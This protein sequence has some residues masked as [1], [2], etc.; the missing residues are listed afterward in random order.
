LVR[1]LSYLIFNVASVTAVMTDLSQFLVVAWV[2]YPDLIP[3][4]G[5]CIVPEPEQPFIERAPHSSS[6]SQ[7]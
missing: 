5:G 6:E 4:E 1:C 2:T 3:N 7:R